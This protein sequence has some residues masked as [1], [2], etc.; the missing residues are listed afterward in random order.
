MVALNLSFS[1]TIFIC[2]TNDVK[3]RTSH[4]FNINA[5]MNHLLLDL[6]EMCLTFRLG[7][8]SGSWRKDVEKYCVTICFFPATVEMSTSPTDTSFS[9]RAMVDPRQNTLYF[10][11]STTLTQELLDPSYLTPSAAVVLSPFPP[12]SSLL[13]LSTIS[14]AESPIA[15]LSV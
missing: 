8:T 12:L 7:G 6:P 9:T 13:S 2:F 1:I 3:L 11:W 14:S 4:C 10:T 15:L 5:L